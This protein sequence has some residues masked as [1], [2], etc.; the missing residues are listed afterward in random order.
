MFRSALVCLLACT[1]A[2]FSTATTAQVLSRNYTGLTTPEAYLALSNGSGPFHGFLSSL[3]PQ[4][5]DDDGR[6]DLLV[7]GIPADSNLQGPITTTLLR[8]T[9]SGTFQ[10]TPGTKPGYCI[11]A[12]AFWGP[13]GYIAPFCTL[14]DLT[15]DGRPDKI[16]A[17]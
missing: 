10:Q 16:F 5:V 15:G 1:F 2:L 7:T 3:S 6:I 12:P 9:G 11:P 17:V 8:N 14:A 4:D 13:A